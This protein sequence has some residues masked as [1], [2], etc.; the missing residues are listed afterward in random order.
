V[1]SYGES[2]LSQACCNPSSECPSALGDT[3]ASLARAV[4]IHGLVSD[5]LVYNALIQSIFRSP[6]ICNRCLKS[7]ASFWH[8]HTLPWLLPERIAYGAWRRSRP[9]WSALAFVVFGMRRPTS[10][11]T[12][13]KESQRSTRLWQAARQFCQKGH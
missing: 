3:V 11:R 4:T 1:C 8:V 6:P 13:W 12:R 7:R 2:Y 5:R 10:K 9:S